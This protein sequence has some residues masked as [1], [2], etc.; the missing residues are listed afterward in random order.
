MYKRLSNNELI[1]LSIPQYSNEDGT[2]IGKT[3]ADLLGKQNGVL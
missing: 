1:D 3:P 2:L